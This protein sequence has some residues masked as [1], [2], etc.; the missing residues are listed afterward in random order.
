MFNINVLTNLNFFFI[1][2]RGQTL[3]D[4]DRRRRSKLPEILPVPRDR[5]AAGRRHRQMAQDGPGRRP[6]R[7]HGT[8]EKH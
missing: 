4:A 3:G 8:L 7:L 6:G 1:H 2:P 5:P